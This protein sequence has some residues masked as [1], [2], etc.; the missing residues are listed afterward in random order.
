M[1][2]NIQRI[3]QPISDEAFHAYLSRYNDNYVA[4][5][6]SNN[7]HDNDGIST[8]GHDGT[9]AS[10]STHI[11]VDDVV[12]TD[13]E[14]IDH[15]AM[16]RVQELRQ[17]VRDKVRNVLQL[18]QSTLQRAITITERQVAVLLLRNKI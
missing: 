10:L 11:P 14:L 3:V 15:V 9:T 4:C 12:F 18:R 2:Q 7:I 5:L 8:H 16:K 1:C 6:P 17:Q 13:D